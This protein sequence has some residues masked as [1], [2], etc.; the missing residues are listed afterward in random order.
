[1]ALETA[2][3][4][5]WAHAI[6]PGAKILLVEANSGTLGNLLSAVSAAR[7]K[8][9]VVAVSMSWGQYEWF[10]NPSAEAYYDKNLF[11]T[12]AGHTGFPV[13]SSVRYGGQSG[14]FQVGGTSAGAPQWSALLAIADQ[15]RQLAGKGT[16]GNWSLDGV[17][18]TLPTLYSVAA[19]ASYAS[20]FHDITT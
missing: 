12:P 1:W 8:P 10:L 13:Y 11:V 16:P 18:Q 6:A 19:G 4:V 17:S 7:N 5:E 3:D 20:D 9:G 15:G 14:W 2:L